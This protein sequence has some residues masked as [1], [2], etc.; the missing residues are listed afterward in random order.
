MW[1]VCLSCVGA[2]G[3]TMWL[4]SNPSSLTPKSPLTLHVASLLLI[5][6]GTAR[7][8][9]VSLMPVCG[10]VCPYTF[11]VCVVR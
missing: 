5:Q 9:D 3:H 11:G 10:S 6:G 8:Q 7:G 4:L 1:T 2:A